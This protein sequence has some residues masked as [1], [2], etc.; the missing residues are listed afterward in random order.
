M[1]LQRIA[2]YGFVGCLLAALLIL[3]PFDGGRSRAQSYETSAQATDSNIAESAKP[4]VAATASPGAETR[5]AGALGRRVPNFVLAD[6]AG[7]E[8][9]LADCRE[10]K[11]VVVTFINCECPISNQYLPVLNELHQQYAAQGVQFAAINSNAGDSL[12]K[13]AAHAK[14]FDIAFP[15]LSDPRQAAAAILGATRTCETFVLDQQRVVRYQG[16]VDD[17]YQYQTKR[18]TPTRNDLALALDDLIADREVAVKTTDVAGCLISYPRRGAPKGEV[19]Y[20]KQVARILQEKC[21]DCHHSN[22]A[23]PFSLLSYNDAVNWSAMIKE[24]ILQRRMPPWHADPRY[25]NFRA[26]RRLSQDEIDT[27]VAWVD[28]G[29]P[30]GNPQEAPANPEYPDGWRIGEPDVIFELPEEVT[31]PAKGVIPY[32]YFQTPTNFTEDMYIQAAEARPGNRTVVHHIVLFYKEPGRKQGNIEKNWV[33]GAAPGNTPLQLPVG[34]GRRI[35]AG[36]SLIW[37]MHYTATGKVEKDRSQYAFKFCK[38][39]PEREARIESIANQGFRIPPGDA[40]YKVESQHTF[41]RPALIYSF[42]PHMHVRGKDFVFKA[43]FPDG[44]SEILLS[45][46]QYDF[47]WQSAYRLQEPKRLPAGTRIEC[48]AH[49]DNS[50]GN[51]ANPD[52]SKPVFWGDQTWEEMMIG[53]V[54]YVWDQADKQSS[55][56]SK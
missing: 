11:F 17:R 41:S 42:S 33:D 35:P 5:S 8:V 28:D 55:P 18:E 13:I 4:V 54:D 56:A 21:Q 30:E 19:T 23:A 26:E 24:V 34:V 29:A 10:M 27:L 31:I 53:Y 43:I 38:T 22:T 14:Q 39:K 36:A 16:R 50:K 3:Q 2:S 12:D 46:P 40:N 49:F 47:N 25:G 6:Q 20:S 1:S 48:V 45:V 52:P 15:V 44:T 37:Q 51:P 32:R 7:K 9:A